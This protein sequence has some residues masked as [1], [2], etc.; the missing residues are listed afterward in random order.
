M[1][2]LFAV[3]FVGLAFYGLV[4]FF[5]RKQIKIEALEL[6]KRIERH[7]SHGSS[8]LDHVRYLGF[9]G[10]ISYLK[11]RNRNRLPILRGVIEKVSKNKS[12]SNTSV[13]VIRQCLDYYYE[14]TN[15]LGYPFD[16]S[17]EKE[18]YYTVKVKGYEEFDNLG[19]WGSEK[20][21]GKYITLWNEL[22]ELSL[23]LPR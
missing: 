21:R 22:T 4:F 18:F 16:N 12:V 3:F 1:E 10:L 15:K 6:I 8:S 9:E 17:F 14:L 20:E 23:I 5:S 11:G 7:E 2:G 13:D 19:F